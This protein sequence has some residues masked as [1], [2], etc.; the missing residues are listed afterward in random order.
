MVAD[1]ALDL[2]GALK[3]VVAKKWWKPTAYPA[4]PSAFFEASSE[5][6]ERRAC[7]VLGFQRSSCRYVARRTM[8]QGLLD[9]I[10]VH[11]AARPRFGYRRIHVLLRRG[12][13]ARGRP[14]SASIASTGPR[15]SPCRPSAVALRRSVLGCPS[16]GA[17]VR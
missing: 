1:Q 17:Q 9:D 6:S 16:A 5:F 10:R 15:A 7:A 8:V 4:K 14:P 13:L 11:A 12:G 2:P 3:A